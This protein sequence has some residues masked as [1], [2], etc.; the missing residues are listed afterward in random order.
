MPVKKTRH[1][2]ALLSFGVMKSSPSVKLK[3]DHTPRRSAE[4][5]RFDGLAG[6]LARVPKS[7]LDKKRAKS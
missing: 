1:P 4:F 5:D 3:Q 2:T 7:E 6:K